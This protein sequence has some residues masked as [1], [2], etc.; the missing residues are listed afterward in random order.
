[1]MMKVAFCGVRRRSSDGIADR[2]AG[3][4]YLQVKLQRVVG[5]IPGAAANR[6]PSVEVPRSASEQPHSRSTAVLAVGGQAR[7]STGRGND[8]HRAELRTSTSRRH[9]SVSSGERP[10]SGRATDT[11]APPRR[12]RQGARH[13]HTLFYKDNTKMLFGDASR[14]PRRSSARWS[15]PQG[16]GRGPSGPYSSAARSHFAALAAAS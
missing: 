3:L 6:C 4:G 15:E 12:P 16:A 1:M 8:S 10:A 5:S 13:R 11:G 14:R 2:F 7:S 9:R